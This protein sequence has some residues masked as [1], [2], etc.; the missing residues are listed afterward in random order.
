MSP[1]GATHVR[2]THGPS[3]SVISQCHTL[4]APPA[5]GRTGRAA[6]LRFTRCHGAASRHRVGVSRRF[7]FSNCRSRHQCRSHR[8]ERKPQRVPLTGCETGS[9]DGATKAQT[10]TKADA[11]A[12]IKQLDSELRARRPDDLHVAPALL[13]SLSDAGRTFYEQAAWKRLIVLVSGSVFTVGESRH[14]L[15]RAGSR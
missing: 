6:G 1:C 13:K 2:S 4:P 8:C 7:R 9:T 14:L 5:K 12:E 15:R 11:D 10:E 3:A